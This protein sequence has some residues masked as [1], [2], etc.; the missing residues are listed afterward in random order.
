VSWA[1]RGAGRGGNSYSGAGVLVDLPSGGEALLLAESLSVPDFV[2]VM[3]DVKNGEINT[4][5]TVID[6]ITEDQQ[7][8]YGFDESDLPEPS[9]DGRVMMLLSYP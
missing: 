9:S 1:P 6:A 3:N 8:Y 7:E 5:G 2:G 4:Q